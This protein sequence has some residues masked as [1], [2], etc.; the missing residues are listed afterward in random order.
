[1]NKRQL[2]KKLKKEADLAT[3]NQL[4]EAVRQNFHREAILLARIADKKLTDRIKKHYEIADEYTE[5]R[6]YHEKEQL[7]RATKELEAAIYSLKVRER[8]LNY[9][10]G[11]LIVI[12][13]VIVVAHII[14][15]LIG[16]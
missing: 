16:G 11:V 2:K 10:V 15:W 8:N 14:H 9:Q 1:M 5:M 6:C 3:V 13:V 12:P 4:L 7:K